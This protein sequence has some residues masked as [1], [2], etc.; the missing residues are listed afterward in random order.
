M[1]GA[2]TCSP[3][4]AIAIGPCS[5]RTRSPRTGASPKNCG[6]PSRTAIACSIST[7]W[8]W[9]ARSSRRH[10]TTCGR[11]R[12]PTDAASERRS[13]TWCRSSRTRK[14]GVASLTSCT[15]TSGRSASPRCSLGGWRS[16]SRLISNCGR[17][18]NPDPTVEEVIRNYFI[19]QPVLW[20]LICGLSPGSAEVVAA[21]LQADAEPTSYTS[22]PGRHGQEP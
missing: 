12:C 3:I 5:C 22:T 9:S 1:S 18:S 11:S 7:R 20:H 14:H 15:S 6:G 8:R 19:R 2:K 13:P 21:P 17:G 4:A 10:R 16:T